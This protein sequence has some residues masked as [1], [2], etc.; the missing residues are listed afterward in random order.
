MK[1][2]IVNADDFGASSGICRGI[3]QAHH[4]GIV[5]S[6]SLMV[7]ALAAKEALLLSRG[8]PNLSIG[9][10]V[11]FTNEGDPVVDLSD[12][13][14]CR[15]ELH[16]QFDLFTELMSRLPTH[17]DSHQNVHRRPHL[18]PFF[19][20][21][22]SRYGLPMREHSRARYFKKFYGQWDHGDTHLEWISPANLIQM[23]GDELSDGFTELGCHPGYL[24]PQFQSVYHSEREAE[25]NTLC[26]PS[27]RAWLAEKQIQL[28]G[29]REFTDLSRIHSA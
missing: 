28:I 23:L 25:L 4:G 22:A 26:D 27:V 20:D 21:L 19:L 11:N 1:Y 7:N 15:D 29:F 17:V 9:L 14:T 6:T 10:H 3:L 5:T 13:G 12:A 8:A 16:R 24:D 18:L 2:L